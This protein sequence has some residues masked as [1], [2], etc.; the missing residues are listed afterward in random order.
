M[1]VNRFTNAVDGAMVVHRSYD[2]VQE[3]VTMRS[4]D[5]EPDDFLV[6]PIHDRLENATLVSDSHGSTATDRYFPDRYVVSAFD[7]LLFR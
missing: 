6:R 3:V 4:Q 7:G 2:F 1:H 5:V